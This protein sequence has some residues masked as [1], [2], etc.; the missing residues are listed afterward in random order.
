MSEWPSNVASVADFVSVGR[1][2]KPHGLDGSFVVEGASEAEERFAA[3]ATLWVD[4][5]PARVVASKRAGGRPVIRL[6]R[7]VRRGTQLHVRR[8]DLPAPEPNS[9][10]VFDLVGLCVEEEGGRALGR[11]RDVASY[12]A[13]D[14]LELDSGLMLPLVE[15]CIREIDLDGRRIVIAPGFA[16]PPLR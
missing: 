2:G 7:T 15:D 10:Y 1:V 12:P 8:A 6:D 3:D 5:E 11:V 13:N 4:G 16:E 14:V 9:Y